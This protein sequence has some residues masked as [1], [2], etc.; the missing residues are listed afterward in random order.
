MLI[1][2]RPSQSRASRA[3]MSGWCKAAVLLLA[4]AVVPYPALAQEA[5]KEPAASGFGADW[6]SWHAGNSVSDMASL[7][8]GARDFLA[9][10][11]GCHALKYERYSRLG[12]D[13]SISP[14]LLQKDLIPSSRKAS[15]YIA[16]PMPAPD[17]E[18]W[19]GKEPPDL[20]LIARSRGTDY[21]YQYLMTFYVDPTRPTGTNNLAL[22]ATAMPAVLSSLEGLKRAVFK[23]V[24][25]RGDSG[26]VTERVFDHFETLAPG[27]LSRDEYA[28]FVRDIVNFLDYVGEPQQAHR[29]AL[30]VWVVLF[31]LVFTWLAWLL[32]KE[33]WKDVQ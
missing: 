8:R 2:D 33:Y 17:A 1:I 5:A 21:L 32:K 19:F 3:T 25:T 10:C 24:Q 31:L 26:V 11:N 27:Q 9:Y 20:S 28:A 29:R 18:A 15:D 14:D 30:G 16:T 12:Q 4:A 13:L 6:E 7:Q 22:D 23:N